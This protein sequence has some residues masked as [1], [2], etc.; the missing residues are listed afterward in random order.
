[1]KLI[2]IIIAI[3]IW[4][5]GTMFPFAANPANQSTVVSEKQTPEP[6][7]VA[8]PTPVPTEA[9]TPDPAPTIKPAQTPSGS[10]GAR[11]GENG[12]IILPPV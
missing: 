9:E 6:T 10:E 8:T 12:D 2:R 5:F 4:L 7:A 3:L 1:M 11:P